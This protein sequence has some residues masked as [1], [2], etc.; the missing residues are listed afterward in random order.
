MVTGREGSASIRVGKWLQTENAL[1]CNCVI[2][3][4]KQYRRGT[5]Q[6]LQIGDVIRGH[7]WLA[8]ELINHGLRL[9]TQGHDRSSA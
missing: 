5:K 4:I 6:T 3:L 1:L 7:A 8:S 9:W 2:E